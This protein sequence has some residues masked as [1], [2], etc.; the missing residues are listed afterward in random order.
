MMHLFPEET[1]HYYDK[2]HRETSF[3]RVDMSHLIGLH[4]VHDRNRNDDIHGKFPSS[5][6]HST[7]ENKNL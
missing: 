1:K 4:S 6:P 3:K 7:Y 5:N 2:I